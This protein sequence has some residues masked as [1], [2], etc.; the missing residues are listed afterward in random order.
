MCASVNIF[1]AA[2]T[3]VMQMHAETDGVRP[4]HMSKMTSAQTISTTE[5]LALAPEQFKCTH[6][7]HWSCVSL[8]MEQFCSICLV[9]QSNHTAV[10]PS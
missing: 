7:M 4:A 10:S 3:S 9:L 6:L 2:L 8:K 1:I 5:H